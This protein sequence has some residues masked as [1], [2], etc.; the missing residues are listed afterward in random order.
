MTWERYK[1]NITSFEVELRIGKVFYLRSY[2]D[3]TSG[4]TYITKPPVCK[5]KL[6]PVV[7]FSE[8]NIAWDISQSVSATGTIDTFDIDWG[9]PTDIGSL[10]SQNW[11]SDPLTGN[12]QY[13]AES[14]YTVTASVTDTLGVKSKEQ[15]VEVRIEA[16]NMQRVYISTIDGGIFTLTPGTEPLAA[17]EGLTGGHLNIR[18]MRMHPAYKGLPLNEQHLWCATEDGV[19]FSLDG[20]ISWSVISEAT[21]GTPTNTVGDAPAPSAS[22]PDNIDIAFDPQDLRRVYLLRTT[23]TRSWLYLTDDYGTT[24]SNTQAVVNG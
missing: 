6:A 9:G 22:D 10:S 14:V 17:N 20:A 11:A 5:L 12:V 13:T 24:W 15:K 23:A 19:T 18:S 2:C 3:D 8:T 21:L 1:S 4:T 7:Q 16:L